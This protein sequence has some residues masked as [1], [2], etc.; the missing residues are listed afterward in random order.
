MTQLIALSVCCREI[1]AVQADQKIQED[2]V[3]LRVPTKAAQSSK[4][5][6]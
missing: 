3:N 1:Y 2:I 4:D 6:F 5:Y